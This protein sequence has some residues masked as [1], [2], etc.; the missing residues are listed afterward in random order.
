MNS[1]YKRKKADIEQAFNR[2]V[3]ELQEKRLSKDGK[4]NVN[5][6]FLFEYSFRRIQ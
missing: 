2:A 1:R 4:T 5:E 6:F 3:V